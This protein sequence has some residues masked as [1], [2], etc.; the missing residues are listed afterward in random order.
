MESGTPGFGMSF[1]KLSD[2]ERIGDQ[3]DALLGT[4]GDLARLRSMPVPA[5]LAADL[6]LH[7]DA[8]ESDS[9]VWLRITIDGKVLPKSPRDLIDQAPAKPVIL[10]SNRLEFGPGR[11]ERDGFLAKAFGQKAAT[12]R[13]Y[14]R[15]GQAS[16]PA[17]PRLGTVEEQIGTDVTF[18]CPAGRMAQILAAKGAPVWQ[19]EFDAAP[20]GG[21]TSHAAEIPYVFGDATFAN[22]LSLKPYWLNFIRSGDPNGS[23]LALWPTFTPS[24]PEHVLFSDGGVTPQGPLRRETCSLLDRI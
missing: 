24:Q 20:N 17:D 22:G 2:A 6:K 16:R 12:A 23:G 1:R 8:V 15:L 5:L 11:S 7:D 10:G 19:Y 13:A 18:R 9:M 14:Y 21:K 4:G 3:A